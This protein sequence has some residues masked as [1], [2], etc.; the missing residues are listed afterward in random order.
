MS[1]IVDVTIHSILST[2]AIEPDQ[3]HIQTDEG[4]RRF[5][6]YRTKSGSFRKETLLDD[7]TVVGSYGWVDANGILRI[8]DYIADDN[9]YR[10]TKDSAIPLEDDQD[11]RITLSHDL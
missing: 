7:G 4:K 5:F 1:L 11:G 8:Y 6:K 10:V 3:Y 2:F 9:G